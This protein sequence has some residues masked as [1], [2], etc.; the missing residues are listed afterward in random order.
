M[1]ILLYR[2]HAMRFLEIQ[3]IVE[4]AFVFNE[5]VNGPQVNWE[6]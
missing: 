4:K 2:V 3:K 5:N 1:K 6:P